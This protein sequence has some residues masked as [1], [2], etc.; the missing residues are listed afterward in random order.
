MFVC[1]YEKSSSNI[2]N[3]NSIIMRQIKIKKIL[4]AQFISSLLALVALKH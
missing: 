1:V 2:D 3:I 4:S